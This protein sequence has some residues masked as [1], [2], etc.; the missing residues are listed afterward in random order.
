MLDG[1][2]LFGGQ[3]VVEDV[4]RGGAEVVGAGVWV[5]LV[6]AEGVAKSPGAAILRL[7]VA[8]DGV[9]RGTEPAGRPSLRG[10]PTGRFGGMGALGSMCFLTPLPLGRPGPRF[11]GV[12]G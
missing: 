6:S 1:Q 9:P 7:R 3:G 8:D 4:L 2:R 5:L 10:R 11:T 12:T